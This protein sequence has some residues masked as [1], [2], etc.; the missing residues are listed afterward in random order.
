MEYITIDEIIEAIAGEIV[1]KGEQI[2]LY[3]NVSTR[4]KSHKR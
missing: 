4:Y 3:N 1:V 2:A